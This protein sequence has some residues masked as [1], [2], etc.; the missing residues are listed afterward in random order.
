MLLL[1]WDNEAERA[2]LGLEGLDR[3]NASTRAPMPVVPGLFGIGIEGGLGTSG[4]VQMA[5]A[6][7]SEEGYRG[8]G[9]A[10]TAYYREPTMEQLQPAQRSAL[11]L[12]SSSSSRVRGQSA[13]GIREA[14]TTD[15]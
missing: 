3:S 9:G 11:S 1:N 5:V 13:I 10:F 14:L 6:V 12:R 4:V 7:E 8:S 15:G 2:A